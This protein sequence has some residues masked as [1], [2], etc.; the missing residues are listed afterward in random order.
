MYG[1][2]VGEMS[3]APSEFWRMKPCDF[4]HARHYFIERDIREFRNKWE[5]TRLI[6]YYSAVHVLRKNT[7]IDSFM[8]LTWD[9]NGVT[10]KVNISSMKDIFEAQL[11][12]KL[13]DAISSKQSK[14]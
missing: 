9:N 6:A 5:Q 2:A 7:K 11:P 12:N 14:I 8:P 13:S 10:K 3:I 4:F 1:M